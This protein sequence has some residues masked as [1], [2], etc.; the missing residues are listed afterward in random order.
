M[1][2]NSCKCLQNNSSDTVDF[3]KKRASSK[4]KQDKGIN[5]AFFLKFNL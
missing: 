4:F 2:A 3:S 5:Q 1:G